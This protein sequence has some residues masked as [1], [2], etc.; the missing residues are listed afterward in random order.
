MC[1]TARWSHVGRLALPT[2]EVPGLS[3]YFMLTGSS[4]P[5][6]RKII[7]MKDNLAPPLPQ[8]EPPEQDKTQSA[9]PA[10][11]PEQADSDTV[12]G[13]QV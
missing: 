11:P 12:E 9:P 7:F 4:L 5:R 1:A 6:Y 13:L 2:V 10:N 8:S 3:T